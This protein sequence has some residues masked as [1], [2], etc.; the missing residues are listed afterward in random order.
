MTG[1]KPWHAGS[2]A[3]RAQ[4]VRNAAD[5]NPATRCWRCGLTKAEHG[6]PWQAGHH[7]DGQIDG[8]LQAECERCNASAGAVRGNRMRTQGTTRR[9]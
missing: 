2:Y 5:A 9:W 4:A 1:R 3:R 8:M 7:L 6:R